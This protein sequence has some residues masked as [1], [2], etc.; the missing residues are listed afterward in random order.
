M[1]LFAVPGDASWNLSTVLVG[2]LMTNQLRVPVDE[3]VNQSAASVGVTMGNRTGGGALAAQANGSVAKQPAHLALGENDDATLVPGVGGGVGND[4]KS[5][6]AVGRGAGIDD[7]ESAW[8][9]A[10]TQMMTMPSRLEKSEEAQVKLQVSFGVGGGTGDDSKSA[11][12]VAEVQAEMT[13]TSRQYWAVL[14]AMG[15]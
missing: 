14:Q 4:D 5:G 6:R 3:P 15:T 7:V 2:A 1:N 13:M 8:E 10:K 9:P 12:G 11:Q